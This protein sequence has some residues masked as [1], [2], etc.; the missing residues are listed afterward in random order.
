MLQDFLEFG[1]H[2]VLVGFVA[3]TLVQGPSVPRLL[4]FIARS[5]LNCISGALQ[6]SRQK[7][8]FLERSL[9]HPVERIPLIPLNGTGKVLYRLLSSLRG[10]FSL[11]MWEFPRI[12]GRT[13]HLKIVELLL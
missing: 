6:A 3:S 4:V 10:S 8:R 13:S 9:L 5:E 11:S 2:T 7:S 1:L 12:R